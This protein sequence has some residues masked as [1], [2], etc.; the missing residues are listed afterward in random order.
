MFSGSRPLLARSTQN[1]VYDILIHIIRKLRKTGMRDSQ[2]KAK[3][4]ER[5]RGMT[6]ETETA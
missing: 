3:E 6:R 2:I 5:E 4:A 1:C